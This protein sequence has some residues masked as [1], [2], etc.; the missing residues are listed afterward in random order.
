MTPTEN[1]KRNQTTTGARRVFSQG[2]NTHCHNEVWAGRAQS[3]Q[4]LAMGWMVQGTNP[5]G[6]EICRTRQPA[7]EPTQPPMQWVPVFFPGIKRPERGVDHPPHLA[8]RLK[9]E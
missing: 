1:V 5:G 9:K 7:L 2:D 6:G 4:R 3:V 8:P